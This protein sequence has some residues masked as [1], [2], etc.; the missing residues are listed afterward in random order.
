MLNI[1][2]QKYFERALKIFI[3]ATILLLIT[4]ILAFF[5]HPTEEVIKQLG[6]KSP[7]RVSETHGFKNV[8]GFITTN[9]FY[10]PIQMLIL[11]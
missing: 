3:M 6:S 8:W 9:G 5:F 7:K 1:K 4:I 10:V 2:D 11:S